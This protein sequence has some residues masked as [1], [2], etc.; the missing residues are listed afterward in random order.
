ML[1]HNCAPSPENKCNSR[2]TTLSPCESRGRCAIRPT[3]GR[4]NGAA[5]GGEGSRAAVAR[6]ESRS[7]K[8]TEVGGY[9]R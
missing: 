5:G 3:L 8:E 4:V 1:L 9:K 7:G 6:R 2:A